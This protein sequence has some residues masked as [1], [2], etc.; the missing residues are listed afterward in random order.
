MTSKENANILIVGDEYGKRRLAYRQMDSRNGKK[1]ALLWLNGLNSTMESTKVASVATWCEQH[2]IGL[3]QF[4]YSGHGLSDGRFIDGTIGQWLADT[5]E[6]LQ[7]LT[8]GPLVVV[9]S[10]MGGWLALLL[11]R[12]HLQNLAPDQPSRLQGLVLIAPALDLTEDLIWNRMTET[13]RQILVQDRVFQ[14]PDQ[15][16][17]APM[18]ISARLIE[19]GRNH[20]F[21]GKGFAPRCPVRIIQGM[22]DDVVPWQHAFQAL[23]LLDEDDIQYNLIKN[24]D[25]RLSTPQDIGV[26]I[27]LI[28][29]LVRRFE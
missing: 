7:R 3:T 2:G 23:N 21:A 6:I 18:P 11:A 22:Q 17:D 5:T 1:P 12:A 8:S 4:D 10:S 25:H 28:D 19:E 9:G 24:G 13:T 14:R 29:G 20:L 26:L 27:Q 16:G 15:Y